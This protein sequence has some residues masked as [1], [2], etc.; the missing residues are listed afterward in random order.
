VTVLWLGLG[1]ALVAALLAL[2]GVSGVRRP[3]AAAH[4]YREVARRRFLRVDTRGLSVHGVIDGRAVWVGEVMTGHGAQRRRAIIAVVRFT[5]PLGLGLHVRRRGLAARVRR[6]RRPLL[7]PEPDLDRALAVEADDVGHATRLLA[8]PVPAALRALTSRWPDLEL[9]DEEVRAHLRTPEASADIVDR[10]VGALLDLAAAVELSRA[11][12]PAVA[13]AEPWQAAARALGLQAADWL[14]GARGHLEG[15][16]VSAAVWRGEAGIGVVVTV[17]RAPA[18][19][20]GFV[21]RP[22][23]IEGDGPSTAGQDIVVGDPAFDPHFIVQ[24]WDPDSARGV[25]DADVRGALLRLAAG[26]AV[27]VDDA[28]VSARYAGLVDPEPAIRAVVAL[29]VS[30]DARTPRTDPVSLR[31]QDPAPSWWSRA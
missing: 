30:L 17:Q 29:A 2:S 3:I 19:P 24:A 13:N 7:L 26:A 27:R 12:L 15:L 5:A 23:G 28:A 11:S 1:C 4:A 10:L 18:P 16:P 20:T 31:P 21:V 6:G 8:G 9:E 14:P 22:Q 25:L